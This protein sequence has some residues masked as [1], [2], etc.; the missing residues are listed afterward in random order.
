MW[1][2]ELPFGD[3][4]PDFT[5]AV[6]T[7]VRQRGVTLVER[8]AHVDPGQ[9]GTE[10]HGPQAW[11]TFLEWQQP[12]RLTGEKTRVCRRKMTLRRPQG[13]EVI[14]SAAQLDWAP[15]CASPC[16]GPGDVGRTRERHPRTRASSVRAEGERGRDVKETDKLCRGQ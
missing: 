12:F 16:A 5:I 6:V 1:G 13:L 14:Q 11:K 15:A 3:K 8:V 10:I 4:R 2:H 9:G 7:D